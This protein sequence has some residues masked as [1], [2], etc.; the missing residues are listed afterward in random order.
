MPKPSVT[1]ATSMPRSLEQAPRP[2]DVL[3]LVALLFLRSFT[4]RQLRGQSSMASTSSACN[5]ST[6]SDNA[7]V[8][9]SNCPETPSLTPPPLSLR[10]WSRNGPDRCHDSDRGHAPTP[11]IGSSSRNA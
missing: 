5:T 3:L 8:R 1:Q 9:E 6:I 4:A 7:W 11:T 10:R 2:G